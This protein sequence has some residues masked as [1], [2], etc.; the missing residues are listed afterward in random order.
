[1][2]IEITKNEYRDL[3]DIPHVSD[4]VMFGHRIDLIILA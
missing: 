1:M 3:L 4:V 2:N